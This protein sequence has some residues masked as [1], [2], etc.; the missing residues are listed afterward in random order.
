MIAVFFYI[1]LAFMILLSF[2]LTTVYVSKWVGLA[3]GAFG[4]LFFLV[5]V[6]CRRSIPRSKPL[7]STSESF[8][9]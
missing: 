4:M 3:V 8:D 7:I 5:I 9:I 6:L 2:I 1:L